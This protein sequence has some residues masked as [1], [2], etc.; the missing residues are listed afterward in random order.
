[1]EY[2]VIATGGKQYIAVPG[3]KLVLETIAGE[4]GSSITFEQVLLHVGTE[5]V[6]LGLPHITGL[7]V[8]AKIVDQTLADKIR[9]FKYKSKSRYRRTQGHRQH[10]TVVEILTIG[11]KKSDKVAESPKKEAKATKKVAAK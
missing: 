8:E 10:Q 9:V 5:G 11:G 1:M 3:K 6:R 7:A 2:A 4:P